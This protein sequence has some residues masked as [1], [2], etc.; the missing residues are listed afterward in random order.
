VQN[1]HKNDL[2]VIFNL[3]KIY[4]LEQGYGKIIGLLNDKTCHSGKLFVLKM[5]LLFNSLVIKEI[6]M[7][8]LISHHVLK[9]FF[10]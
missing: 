3:L 9:E 2:G 1:N 10:E 7:A 8:F 4:S 5:Y 6:D